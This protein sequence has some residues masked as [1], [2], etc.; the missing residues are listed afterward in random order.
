MNNEIENC[1]AHT[2]FEDNQVTARDIEVIIC[3]R[4]NVLYIFVIQ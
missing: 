1:V 3:E 4:L 2:T